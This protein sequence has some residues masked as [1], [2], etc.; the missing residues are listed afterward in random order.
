MTLR[1]L[2]FDECEQIRVW[3]N[4]PSVRPMLR[5]KDPITAEQQAL[6]YRDVVCNPTS[7]HKYYGLHTGEVIENQKERNAAAIAAH[8][9]HGMYWVDA[10]IGVTGL[11]YLN[12][13][14]GE[15]EISLVLGPQYRGK[16]Y[17][18]QAVDAVLAEAKRL[19]L[20]S[21]IGECYATGNL[22]FWRKQICRVPAHWFSTDT[23]GTLKWGW[24]L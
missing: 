13:Q 21:V 15:A 18:T 10:F 8:V 11:T 20:R 24:R 1:P 4:D 9:Y 23:A 7:I 2:T 19:G 6:F 16:G 22:G 12:R 3:R 5:T 14:D 17:G